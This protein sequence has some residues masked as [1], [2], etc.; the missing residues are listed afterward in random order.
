MIWSSNDPFYLPPLPIHYSDYGTFIFQ[1]DGRGVLK[2]KTDGAYSIEYV[3]TD[4]TLTIIKNGETIVY[5]LDWKPNSF[6]IT[7]NITKYD[8]AVPYTVMEKYECK[9]NK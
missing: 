5:D 4:K 1:K 8:A 2:T 6:T 7:S 3:N 9:K